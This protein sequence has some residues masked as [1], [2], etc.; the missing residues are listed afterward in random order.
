MKTQSVG[1][2]K[3]S[4]QL[5]DNTQDCENEELEAHLQVLKKAALA[6][7]IVKGVKETLKAIEANR[8]K[9][10]FITKDCEDDSYKKCIRDYSEMYSVPIIEVDSKYLI[11]DTVM[12]G[13]P[14]KIIINKARSNGKEPKVMPNC[15]VAAILAYGDVNEK[16]KDKEE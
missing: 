10:V 14:S 4:I 7:I 9:V 3:R 8:C 16:F 11:R 6:G 15:Y 5:R 13:I 1:S 2:T 12:L